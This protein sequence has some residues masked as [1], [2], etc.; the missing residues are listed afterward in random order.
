MQT[1]VRAAAIVLTVAATGYMLR[2]GTPAA[3]STGSVAAA[4]RPVD[5]P[6]HFMTA[7]SSDHEYFLSRHQV[8]PVGRRNITLP[9]LMYHY[10]RKPPS[11]R[12]DWLGYKLSVSPADFAT[13][14]DWLSRNGFHPVDFNDVRAYFAGGQP[15]PTRPVVITFDDGYADLYTAAFPILSSHDFKA[16]AYIVSS[17]VGW[18]GYATA[19]QILQMDHNGI[20]IASHTVDHA[21]LARSSVG[22]VRRELVESKR[23]LERLLGRPVLDFAYPSGQFNAMVVAEVKQAGYDTAVTTTES[24]DHSF[25]DRFVWARVR[26]GGGESLADFAHNLGTP[27]PAITITAVDIET[28]GAALPSLRRPPHRLFK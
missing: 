1:I 4:V 28:A 23:S 25:A 26:V 21:N 13:Q 22:S 27:M 5:L 19:D 7:P 10:I 2:A 6:V 24:V 14:M 15:L 16:V 12:N 17:F 11:M 9:I 18:P 3:P 8:V 20:E